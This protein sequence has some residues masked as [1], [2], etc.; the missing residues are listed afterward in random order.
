MSF[1]QASSID[2]RN[3]QRAQLKRALEPPA[4]PRTRNFSPLFRL[5]AAFED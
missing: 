3:A 2:N 4:A 5:G 1:L